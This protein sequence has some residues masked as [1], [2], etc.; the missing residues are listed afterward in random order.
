[1]KKQISVWGYVTELADGRFDWWVTCNKRR[2]AAYNRLLADRGD[3]PLMRMILVADDSRS[4]TAMAEFVA[5]KL[6]RARGKK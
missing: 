3:G 1:V 6:K 5:E 2:A 4:E